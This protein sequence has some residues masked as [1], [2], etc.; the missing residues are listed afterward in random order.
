MW[1]AT[2]DMVL[3]IVMA[4]R[5]SQHGRGTD[6]HWYYLVVKDAASSNSSGEEIP[7]SSRRQERGFGT[8]RESVT[9]GNQMVAYRA[10]RCESLFEVGIMM[11]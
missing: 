8:Q 2:S 7:E 11:L 9:P 4:F 1:A 5:F 10:N 3:L 6:Y